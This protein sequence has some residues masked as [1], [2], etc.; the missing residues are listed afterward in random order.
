VVPAAATK[1]VHTFCRYCLAACGL[2]VTVDESANRV[3]KIS[4][5][6]DN[7]YTWQDFCAKGRTAAE[8]VE[9]PRRITSPMR[10]VGD[11]YVEATWEE[12]VSDIAA[13]M[14]AIIERDG[15]DAVGVYWGNPA[16]FSASNLPLQTAWLDAV[17][18]G[19]RYAVGSVDQNAMHIVADAMY[20]SAL[21][22]LVSDIDQ[23][24][25]FLIIG[26][27]PAVSAWN[28][29]ETA[30]N[31]FR[32]MLA[33]QA[34]GATVV[35]V[36]PI[37]TETA[38][39]ADIHVAVR[40]GQDWALL[41]GMLKVIFEEGLEHPGDCADLLHDVDVVRAL[42][43]EADLDDLAA[44]CDV[45]VE[46]LRGVA[47]GFAT[48]RTAM[49]MTRTG[50]SMHTTGTVG[51]WLGQLLNCVTG[52]MDR[53]GGRRFER[54]YIDTLGMFAKFAGGRE[55][56]SR[57]AGRPMVAGNH[58]IAELPDEITTPGRGQVRALVLNSGNPVVSGPEG[59]KLDA[60]LAQL[61][62]LVAVDMVQRESHRHAH[63]LIPAA[64]WL[65]RG[66][67][68]V[69]T[70]QLHEQPYVQ[71]GTQV[72]TPPPGVRNEWE[73]WVDL[74]LRMRRPLFG[75]RGIN[76]FIKGTRLLARVT[77][78]PGLAFDPEWLD[79]L[80]V[81]AGRRLKW[82]DIKAHP[83]GWVYADREY[84]NFRKAL[85]TKDKLVNAAPPAIVAECRRLLSAPRPQAPDGF[86]FQLSNRRRRHSMNS[87]LNELPGLH[88]GGR[89]ND[90][91]LHPDDAAAVGVTTGD[92]VRVRSPHGS[93]ELS[94]R[95]TAD[96]PRRGV[97][98]ADHGWGSRIFDPRGGAEP[99][100]Y[101]ANRNLLVGGADL[102]PLAQTPA[103][104]STYVAVEKVTP[105]A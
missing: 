84:G 41:L 92:L 95:V 34:Q 48:A 59:A 50:I 83:H 90:L 36:D 23:C 14:N 46:Q 96:G 68:M 104:S 8:L 77:R 103:L 65:E 31:G 101:G 79:R 52:R 51:E 26:S 100:S 24:D 9:H 54:G 80:G 85:R 15:P 72:V 5:D 63:W 66:E 64:H 33:R 35:V 11:S 10:R 3:L 25:Y 97:V 40:P 29:L 17:G 58:A 87:W 13:R 22:T 82:K 2:E 98:V 88:R 32:R 102:D 43:A 94:A 81:F 70:S 47:R 53:P 61:D 37:R 44:R 67:L 73:F 49:A 19:S 74:T 55:H 69:L 21:F 38:E 16:G 56:T 28:W 99:V 18:T 39:R 27:N 93:I 62:L 78:R 12:A 75:K 20:G 30:P 57:V 45:P 89:T 91:E 105:P 86:P 6:K 42:A 76:T 71:Y 60:A 4:P 7:P 1:T